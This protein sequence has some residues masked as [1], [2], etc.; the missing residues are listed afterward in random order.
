M[1]A[2]MLLDHTQ[3]AKTITH[4]KELQNLLANTHV[5]SYI[6]HIYSGSI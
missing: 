6:Y 5:D 4:T 1:E 3:K 2:E